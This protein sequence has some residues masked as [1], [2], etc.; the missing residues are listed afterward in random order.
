MKTIFFA[1]LLAMPSQTPQGNDGIVEGFITTAGTNQPIAQVQVNLLPSGAGG[2]QLAT[3]TDAQGHFIFPNLAVGTYMLRA[4]REGYLGRENSTIPDVTTL[5]RV[6]KSQERVQVPTLSLIL[7]A[8]ISGR[9]VEA[10]GAPGAGL[11]M[12]FLRVTYDDRGRRVWMQTAGPAVTDA[13]GEYRLSQ[14]SAGEYYIRASKHPLLTNATSNSGDAAETYF[15]GTHDPAAATAVTLPQGGAVVADF[16]IPQEVTHKVSGKLIS[17]LPSGPRLPMTA[18]GLIPKNSGLPQE[19][20]PE[21][22]AALTLPDGSNGEF[23]IRGVRPGTYDLMASTRAGKDSALSL[24]PLEVRDADVAG[25]TLELR[26]GAEVKGR[27]IVEGSGTF[28]VMASPLAALGNTGGGII[29]GFT[30]G[31]SASSGELRLT[32]ERKDNIRGIFNSGPAAVSADGTVFTFSNIPKGAYDVTAGGGPIFAGFAYV[33]DIRQGGRSIFDEELVVGDTPV[34]SL[35][36]VL[37][38]NG[39]TIE[40]TIPGAK[41]EQIQVTLVPQAA[42]RKNS[43]LYKS[44]YTTPANLTGRFTMRGVAPG[45]YKLFAWEVPGPS[46]SIAFRDPEVLAKYESYGVPVTVQAN[47]T[48][49]VQLQVLPTGP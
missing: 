43:A 10:G 38:T 8:T 18:V 7:A 23:E 48:V 14:F 2:G 33:G 31:G 6:T 41:G 25:I 24:M 3:T 29:A 12:E 37:K 47:S 44:L 28:R 21:L 45:N 15:P 46:S 35:E 27:L 26:T 42:R 9:I 4:R 11:L 5:V 16:Q 13:R 40:G 39:G 20:Q 36:V 30:R 22:L 32:L 19:S 1:M 34:D 17:K 49:T